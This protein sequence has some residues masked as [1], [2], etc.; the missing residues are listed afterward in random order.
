M[1]GRRRADLV[2]FLLGLLLV[3]GVALAAWLNAPIGPPTRT[4]GVIESMQLISRGCPCATVSVD[5]HRAIL[6]SATL[7]VCQ[8]GDRIPLDRRKAPIG[9]R[10]SFPPGSCRW[11]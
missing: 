6:R 4:S 2:G 11:R 1:R 10:Y 8:V 5:G 7:R 9:F 3:A